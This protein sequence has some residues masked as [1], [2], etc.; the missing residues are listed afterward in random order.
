[1]D[2]KRK[3]G[4]ENQSLIAKEARLK[5]QLLRQLE[6][7]NR[8]AVAFDQGYKDEAIRC[9]PQPEGLTPEKKR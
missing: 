2:A 9:M 6:F 8:S 4:P 1:M 3:R 5:N 7:F